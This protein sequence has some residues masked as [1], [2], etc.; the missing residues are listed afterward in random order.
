MKT[1]KRPCLFIRDLSEGW[2][3]GHF[4]PADLSPKEATGTATNP[5]QFLDS[6]RPV[7]SVALRI[8]VASDLVKNTKLGTP[9]AGGKPIYVAPDIDF[10]RKWITNAGLKTTQKPSGSI[11]C[12]RDFDEMMQRNNNDWYTTYVTSTPK[13]GTILEYIGL[14]LHEQCISPNRLYDIVAQSLPDFTTEDAETVLALLR[15]GNSDNCVLGGQILLGSNMS[16]A[17]GFL[18]FC[19]RYYAP[20]PKKTVEYNTLRNI[21]Y[22]ERVEVISG[23]VDLKF[24]SSA[25]TVLARAGELFQVLLADPETKQKL[26]Q[27]MSN[28]QPLTLESD[29]I[30]TF[31]KNVT[32]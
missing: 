6:I 25:S 20:F 18:A 21:G 5:A 14:R 32:K 17:R 27:E 1:D 7:Y 22:F 8:A 30:Q 15:S 28:K 2:L 11:V 9:K 16:R 3:L 10:A 4:D 24:I 19:V 29:S 23:P 13:A 12:V 26:L 31:L